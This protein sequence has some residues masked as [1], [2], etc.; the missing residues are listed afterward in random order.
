MTKGFFWDIIEKNGGDDFMNS[1]KTKNLVLY[2]VLTALVIIL[3]A[4]GATI[5]FGMFSITLTLVPIVIGAALLGAKAG[6]WLG[7]VFSAVVIISGDAA[8]FLAVNIPG[9]IITVIAKGT[10]AGLLTGLVYNALKNIN[11][12]V[13][14]AISA[15]VCPV[16]NTG[17]FLIGCFVFFMDTITMWATQLGFPSASN[18]IIFG[19]VGVNFLL[20]VGANVI[21]SPAIIRLLKIKKA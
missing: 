2:A 12:Y 5:K 18:Y 7:F 8:P 21:L 10:L 1:G 19:L 6:A 13:A 4:V 14:T 11:I 15:I 3:Q 9:T 20:E 17:I 16:V